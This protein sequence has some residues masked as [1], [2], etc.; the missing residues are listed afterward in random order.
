MTD[1]ID[2]P[3]EPEANA[4][5]IVGSPSST[6]VEVS[7]AAEVVEICAS[8]T[9]VEVEASPSDFELEVMTQTKGDRGDRGLPGPRGLTG[10]RGV[11]GPEGTRGREG[12][13]GP[14]GFR[15]PA[16]GAGAQGAP[17]LPGPPGSIDSELLLELVQP[18]LNEA[19]LIPIAEIRNQVN[20]MPKTVLASFM[21]DLAG[22]D[23]S[24]MT[25][26]AGDTEDTFVG[27]VSTVS[28]VTESYYKSMKQTWGMI[29]KTESSMAAIR[30][31]QR[32]VAELN[33]AT[34]QQ[35]TTFIAETG[36]N[37]AALQQQLTTTATQA[38]ST[39]A[40]LTQLSAITEQSLTQV[41]QRIDLLADDQE[42][43][44][45]ALDEYIAENNGSVALLRST[46]ETQADA[47]SA[48]A[49]Q[50]TQLSTKVDGQEGDISELY[51]LVNN[52]GTGE[53]SSHYQIKTQV[54]S[55]DK[56]VMTGMALGAAIGGD[57]SYRSEILF[58][59]DTIGF[60]TKNNGAV[61]QPFIF[62]VANDT[63]FLN[64]VFIKSATITSGKFVE[65]LESD[66]L[67]PGGVPVLRMNFRTGELQM[68]APMS[69]G[70]RMTLNNRTIKVYDPNNVVRVELGELL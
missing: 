60:L 66:A 61:H 19:A 33:Y 47:I 17:G 15:G 69:G 28:M 37:V 56:V 35:L 39:A 11:P 6:S 16:G 2:V 12:P 50:L 68:N 62:D 29:S 53:I 4:E 52:A 57:G 26:A 23:I 38:Y 58:M 67:G 30:Q 7:P 3:L 70:G 8:G 5:I 55:G 36:N 22:D 25:W 27:S 24:D 51:E 18:M 40:S 43:T 41:T 59:A 34:A 49:S 9:L 45:T 31:E 13:D 10:N 46:V 44:V 64:S 21:G 54:T 42:A 1:S 63:A 14:R 32:I 65:W 48:N 20:Q